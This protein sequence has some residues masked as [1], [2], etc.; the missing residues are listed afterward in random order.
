MLFCH[1]LQELAE[2]CPR[3]MPSGAHLTHPVKAQL[4][5]YF[6]THSYSVEKAHVDLFQGN[7]DLIRLQTLE[8]IKVMLE[9]ARC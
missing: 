8:Q 2:N 1:I 4:R 3:T 5:D 9:S 7:L 6:C